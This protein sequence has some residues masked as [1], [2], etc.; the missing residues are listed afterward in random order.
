[1][2]RNSGLRSYHVDDELARTRRKVKRRARLAIAGLPLCALAFLSSSLLIAATFGP[3]HD[4]ERR[5]S[6]GSQ[7]VGLIIELTDGALNR[8]GVS[9]HLRRLFYIGML[10]ASA[11]GFFICCYWLTRNCPKRS[12]DN[13]ENR[14]VTADD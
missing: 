11:F 8:A 2:F 5:E 14:T 3:L 6:P 7:L 10:L 4:R 1:M 9:A 12:S 13:N